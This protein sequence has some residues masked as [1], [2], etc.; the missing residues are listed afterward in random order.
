MPHYPCK[1]EIVPAAPEVPRTFIREVS[2]SLCRAFSFSSELFRL[3]EER[4]RLI[5]LAIIHIS[6]QYSSTP[7]S[8]I[9]SILISIS[10]WFQDNRFSPLSSYNQYNLFLFPGMLKTLILFNKKRPSTREERFVNDL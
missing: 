4:G 9:T 6:P 8:S 10:P 1:V 2:K 7:S 3:C 5:E